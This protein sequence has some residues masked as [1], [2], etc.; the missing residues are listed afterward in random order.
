METATPVGCT[1]MTLPR[2][3]LIP[4]ARA[5]VEEEPRNRPLVQYMATAISGDESNTVHAE[6]IAALTGKYFGTQTRVLPTYFMD[7]PNAATRR[8]ILQ[9]LNIWDCGISFRETANV[10]DSRIRIGRGKRGHYS[11]LGT[12]NYM[13]PITELTMNLQ[14]FTEFTPISEYLRV[15]PH[16]GGHAMAF[17]HEHMLRSIMNRL[18]REATIRDYRQRYGWSAAEV[19]AQVFTPLEE[20]S[21]LMV[22]G[23]PPPGDEDS[24]MCY[25]FEGYLTNDGRPILGGTRPNARDLAFAQH[26]YPKAGGPVDPGPVDPPPPPPPPPIKP[27]PG[28]VRLKRGRWSNPAKYVPN[29]GP[30]RFAI[31]ATPGEALAIEVA[32]DGQWVA[33]VIPNVPGAAPLKLKSVKV[34]RDSSVHWAAI[35]AEAEY[36]LTVRHANARRQGVFRVRYS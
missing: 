32:G 6:Y 19:E 15:V 13:I 29:A 10:G 24:I 1:I 14:D 16:E 5:A 25:R 21:L 36:Y 33:E 31:T 22:P 28:M 17:P 8:M 27:E 9:Y 11:Y 34:D 7:N 30:T 18:N 26:I 12:D 2:E 23:M 35:G 3:L 4:A 20:S